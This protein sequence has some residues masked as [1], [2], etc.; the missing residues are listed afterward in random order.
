MSERIMEYGQNLRK[1]GGIPPWEALPDIGLY[2]D[3]VI[4]FLERM[5]GTYDSVTPSMVNNYVKAGLLPRASG[6]KYGPEHLA[7]LLVAFTLKRVLSMQD[8]KLM[9]GNLGEAEA[10]RNFY[11]EFRANAARTA[12]EMEGVAAKEN[13]LRT[14]GVEA[15]LLA[16]RLAIEAGAR[17]RLAET[18]LYAAQP[19]P[20]VDASPKGAS[21]RRKKNLPGKS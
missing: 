17:S 21:R 14:Q 16:L 7:I 18:I 11:E 8:I 9:M 4:T 1:P 5:L 20:G 3:Q 10:V 2:M 13:E 6:K 19:S 12:L 15:S